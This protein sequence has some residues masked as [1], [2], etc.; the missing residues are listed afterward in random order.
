MTTEERLAAIVAKCR[1]FLS[2]YDIARN[3]GLYKT[4]TLAAYESTIVAIEW[5]HTVQGAFDLKQQIAAAWPDQLLA[6]G[7]R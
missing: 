1:E 7:T 6:G 2:S 5:L 3:H 4:P